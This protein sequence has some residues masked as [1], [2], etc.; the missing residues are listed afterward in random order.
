LWFIAPNLIATQ[1]T[2]P[3]GMGLVPF[4]PTQ[5]TVGLAGLG[6]GNTQEKQPATVGL[7]EGNF[8]G[9]QPYLQTFPNLTAGGLLT[10][11][12]KQ[13]QS[14]PKGT[15]ISSGVRKLT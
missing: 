9:S 2:A 11:H 15:E 5:H 14:Q 10:V 12:Q 8:S 7:T 4:F 6:H 3:A 1:T 13:Q